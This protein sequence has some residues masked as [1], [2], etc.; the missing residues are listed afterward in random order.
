M[1]M[2]SARG[3]GWKSQR[4]EISVRQGVIQSRALTHVPRAVASPGGFARRVLANAPLNQFRIPLAAGL[5]LSPE[6]ASDT[7]P[8][9]RVQMPQGP[10]GFAEAEVAS[11]ASHVPGQFW[12]HL[13]HT[14]PLAAYRE[15]P[16]PLF[17]TVQSLR[18]NLA[19]QLFS[20]RKAESQKL[21]LLRFRHRAL[22]LIHLEL[23]PDR[24]ESLH[25]FH[26][27]LPRPLAANIDITVVRVSNEPVAAPLQLPVQ[28]VQ[29]EVTQQRRK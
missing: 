14:L 24:D 23:Q 3:Q 13:L 18:R 8:D 16:Y 11:P 6:G 29:H 4:G 22:G 1:V 10:R 28:F 19:L 21:P 27:P 12:H 15:L 25:A 17:K 20:A 26:H 7:P 5:P 9:P 2:L